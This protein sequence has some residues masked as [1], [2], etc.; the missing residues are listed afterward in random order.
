MLIRNIIV[1]YKSK[2]LKIFKLGKKGKLLNRRMKTET[3]ITWLGISILILNKSNN[4]P[5]I[6]SMAPSILTN[7]YS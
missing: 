3:M 7:I 4:N 5:K 6:M 2:K 1:A